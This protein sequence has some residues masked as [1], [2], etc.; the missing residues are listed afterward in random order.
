MSNTMSCQMHLTVEH[1]DPETLH[2][3]KLNNNNKQQLASLELCW[4][5]KQ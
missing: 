3:T 4:M 1:P 2:V 5:L